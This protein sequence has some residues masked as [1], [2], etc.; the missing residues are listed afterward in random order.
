MPGIV[1][2]LRRLYASLN[3]YPCLFAVI[4]TA[5]GL[6]AFKSAIVGHMSIA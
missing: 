2:I 4:M 3:D 5:Y 6:F 1:S